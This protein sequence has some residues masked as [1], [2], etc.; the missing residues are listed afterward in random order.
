MKIGIIDYG[1]C[2]LHSISSAI[3]YL[4]YDYKFINKPD[5]ID[6]YE[7]I[8]LPGVGAFSDGMTGLRENNFIDNLCGYVHNGGHFLGICLG[9]QMML[10]ESHE[11]GIHKGLNLIEGQVIKIPS[12]VN[13]KTHKIPHLGWNKLIVMN[14]KVNQIAEM[15]NYVYFVHSYMVKCDSQ[16]IHANTKYN[17]L[18]MPAIINYKNSYGCQFHPEKSG[19]IGLSIIQN[20]INL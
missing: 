10:T 9:M 3:K 19:Q 20:F 13:S 11:F 12:E 14:N 2:N 16:Y 18:I 17:D 15:N 4:N 8:I 7:K 6:K 5:D 1:L